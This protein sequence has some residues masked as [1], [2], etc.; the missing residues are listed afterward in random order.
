[1]GLENDDII[2]LITPEGEI[3]AIVY[4]Y[5]AIRPDVFAVPAGQGHQH[6][7]MFASKVGNNPFKLIQPIQNQ[8]GDLAYAGTKVRIEKTGKKKQLPR[9]ESIPGVYGEEAG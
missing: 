4:L 9:K 3:T 7:G 6:F 1:L 5:P 8:A 2:R